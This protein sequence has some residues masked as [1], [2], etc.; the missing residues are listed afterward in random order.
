MMEQH[1]T[2]SAQL[3]GYL[4]LIPIFPALGALINAVLGARLQKKFGHWPVHAVAISAMVG[5]RPSRLVSAVVAVVT[6]AWSSLRP[7]GTWIGHVLSRK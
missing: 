7:R 6:T 5:L 2:H 1:L 3:A 4:K